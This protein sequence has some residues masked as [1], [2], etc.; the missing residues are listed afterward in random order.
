MRSTLKLVLIMAFLFFF[1]AF[2]ANA[3]DTPNKITC[4]Q[5]AGE[6]ICEVIYIQAYEDGEALRIAS[7]IKAR[8]DTEI[9]LGQDSLFVEYTKDKTYQ[10]YGYGSAAGTTQLLVEASSVKDIRLE[11]VVLINGIRLED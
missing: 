10:V 5:S 8:T 7:H 9:V 3:Q 1:F 11:V 6:Y 4:Q 2:A